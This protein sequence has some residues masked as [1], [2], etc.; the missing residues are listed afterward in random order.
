[1]Q[2][3]DNTNPLQG[4]HPNQGVTPVSSSNTQGSQ[5]SGTTSTALTTD[6]NTTS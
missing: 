2:K 6:N 4:N 5:K 3:R 1:M